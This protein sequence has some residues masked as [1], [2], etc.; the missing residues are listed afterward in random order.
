VTIR[1]IREAII[2]ARRYYINGTLDTDLAEALEKHR[3]PL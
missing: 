1:A 3:E 2:Q